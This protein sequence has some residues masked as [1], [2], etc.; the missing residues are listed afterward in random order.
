MRWTR[1][2]R[3]TKERNQIPNEKVKLIE[4]INKARMEW[5]VAQERLNYVLEEDQIDYVIFMLEA[6]EKRYGMLLRSAK[7]M[8]LNMLD[9]IGDGKRKP[10]SHDY[11][12]KLS[13]GE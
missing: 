5:S 2:L 13:A 10:T 3:S 9:I 8:D 7:K 12:N 1:L 11:M 4:E 6:A